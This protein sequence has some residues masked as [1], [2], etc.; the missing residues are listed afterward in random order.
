MIHIV[1][2]D[3]HP[4]V[5]QGI[6]SLFEK[7]GD[8]QIVGEAAD[9]QEAVEMVQR[10]LPDVIVMD[11][12]MPR[13]NGTQALE[14]IRAL[15]LPTQVVILSMH[16]TNEHIQ[17]ALQA[18]AIGYLLKESAG[19]EVVDAIR[20]AYE[21]RRYLSRKIAETVVDDYVRQSGKDVLDGLSPREREVLQLIA[22]GKTS[23]EA[24]QILS[25]SVKTVETYRSRF[26]QKLG[27]KDMT[28]LI[29]FAIQHGIITLDQ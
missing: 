15:G 13:L 9:G 2:A 14:K 28:A 18:G 24:S 10:L 23:A 17:R 26:M 8:I 21:G 22:E 7:A 29:K 3:D 19:G 1:I 5:R 11:V 27:L 25:L 12:V 6:R 20:S 4:L 16:Y